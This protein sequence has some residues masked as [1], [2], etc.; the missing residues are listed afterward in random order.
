MNKNFKNSIITVVAP[1]WT[2]P[3]AVSIPFF[4]QNDDRWKI[5]LV[6]TIVLF[7]IAIVLSWVFFGPKEF[8]GT[9][10]KVIRKNL[11]NM[12]AIL[13]TF[14][15]FY[16]S[17]ISNNQALFADRLFRSL[18]FIFSAFS[19]AYLLL[20]LKSFSN[21]NL[22]KS[23]FREDLLIMN[24][25]IAAKTEDRQGADYRAI[26]LEGEPLKKVVFNIKPDTPFWRAGLKIVDPNGSILPL[27][28]DESILFHLGSTDKENYFGITSYINGEKVELVNKIF[29][30]DPN[31]PIS[32]KF[33][34]NRNN[35]VK[36]YVN[37]FVEFEPEERIN[38]R[39]LKKAY[40]VGWGDEH[41]YRV[42]FDGIGFLTRTKEKSYRKTVYPTSAS[43]YPEVLISLDSF[44]YTKGRL[45]LLFE[46][47]E[48]KVVTVKGITIAGEKIKIQGFS[49]GGKKQ[50]SKTF[51][52][53]GLKILKGEEV[54]PEVKLKYQLLSSGEM[55][56]AIAKI[57]REKRADGFFN[58][59]SVENTSVVKEE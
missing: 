51:G 22:L 53:A 36:F 15:G 41:N 8:I 7:L 4:L 13:A 54:R 23:F 9:F 38:P 52:I 1:A 19:F 39:L 59:T 20:K 58:I 29:K 28:S 11:L 2:I 30:Y 37:G 33:E 49:I 5:S 3:F 6:A 42:G 31:K 47:N 12:V 55:F 25:W 10:L 48:N 16:F 40:L 26:P 21:F 17:A 35:F 24:K 32:I 50:V 43:S 45:R 44:T 18:L 34:V 46:N 57:H 14:I 56:T 27:R